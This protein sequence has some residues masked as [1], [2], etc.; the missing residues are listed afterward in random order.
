LSFQDFANAKE[1][2]LTAQSETLA[3]EMKQMEE[4]LA[5]KLKLLEDQL[6]TKQK[7]EE[8]TRVATKKER[9]CIEGKP[10]N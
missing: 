10:T 9:S 5:E 6:E 3:A 7:E 8:K 1:N 4:D 2:S